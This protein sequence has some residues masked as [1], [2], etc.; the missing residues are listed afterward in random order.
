[1]VYW[2]TDDERSRSRCPVEGKA[3]GMPDIML[4]R[5]REERF[6][7]RATSNLRCARFTFCGLVART[8]QIIERA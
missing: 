8:V 7:M 5:H 6:R 1:M 3:L 4:A 2:S